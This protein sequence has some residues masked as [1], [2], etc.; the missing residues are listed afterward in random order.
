V[1]PQ[2]DGPRFAVGSELPSLRR[3]ATSRQ[4][5][6]Y[7]AVSGELS[8]IH[9]DERRVVSLGLP[10]IVVHGGLKLA[11]LG[12][13]LTGWS[14]LDAGVRQLEV[15]YRG[16]D[17]VDEEYIL[18]GVIAGVTSRDSTRLVE[19]TLWGETAARQQRTTVGRAV[20]EFYAGGTG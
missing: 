10:G 14:G 12:Q 3:R 7:S 11:W 1:T 6:L 2:E 8:E 13:L 17:F 9:Y 16:M 18:G 15:T 19:V 4:L 20:V 5:V